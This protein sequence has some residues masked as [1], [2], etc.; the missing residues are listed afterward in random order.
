MGITGTPQL[1]AVDCTD[2]EAT[3]GVIEK[4]GLAFGV[5]FNESQNDVVVTYYSAKTKAGTRLPYRNSDGAISQQTIP[6]NESQEIK[7]EV[8]GVPFLFPKVDSDV[9]LYFEFIR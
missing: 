8:A 2:D 6:A 3:T 7:P 9:T 5:V 1:Y 4:R